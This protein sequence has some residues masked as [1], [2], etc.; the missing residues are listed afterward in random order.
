MTNLLKNKKVV[1]SAIIGLA[2]LAV[3]LT[4]FSPILAIAESSTNAS[5]MPQITGSVNVEQAMKEYIKDHQTTSFSEAASIAEKQVTNGA[6]VG[7]HIG[8][9]QG[10]LVYNFFVI[11]TENDTGYS[12]M[13]DAG[14][15]KIL[16]KS[17]GN[18]LKEFGKSFGFGPFGHDSF[19]HDSFGHRQCDKH[20]FGGGWMMQHQ[21][22][23]NKTDSESSDTQ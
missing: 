9:I 21:G 10:Y 16:K 8:I 19:D 5:Q 22:Y 11:D 2:S 17:D 23:M 15:G 6:V 7:G 3:V 18:D 14:D 20:G 1:I 4:V 13:I 12:I